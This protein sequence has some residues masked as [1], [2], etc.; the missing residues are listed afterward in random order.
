MYK[1][2]V[3]DTELNQ[4]QKGRERVLPFGGL[5]SNVVLELDKAADLS[6]LSRS[7]P[8]NE[9]GRVGSR[10]SKVRESAE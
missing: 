8:G 3:I 6:E 1:R 10:F 5:F 9:T 4:K 2:E 7:N